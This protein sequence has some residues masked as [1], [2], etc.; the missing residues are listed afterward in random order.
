[1]ISCKHSTWNL[2]LK[3]VND[4]ICTIMFCFLYIII[5][6]LLTIICMLCCNGEVPCD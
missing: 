3:N 5:L 2:E 4:Y 1:M 6:R